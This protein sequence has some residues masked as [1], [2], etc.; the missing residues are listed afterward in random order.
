MM[1][2]TK[3]K[4]LLNFN[5]NRDR[6]FGFADAGFNREILDKNLTRLAEIGNSMAEV[7][8]YLTEEEIRLLIQRLHRLWYTEADE[9]GI[10]LSLLESRSIGYGLEKS[11]EPDFVFFLQRVLEKPSNWTPSC[12]KGFLHSTLRLWADLNPAVRDA[13]SAFIARHSKEVDGELSK[14]AP[15]ISA[16]GPAKLGKDTRKRKESYLMGPSAVLMPTT[17]LNYSYFSDMLLS[18]FQDVRKGEYDELKSALDLHNQTRTDKILIPA[19]IK[20]EGE[21]NKNLLDIATRRIGDPFDESKWAAFDGA[22]TEQKKDL[23]QARKI[24]L[25]WITQEI[26]R[27]FFEVLCHDRER[28][29]FWSKHAHQITNFTV[30]GSNWSR[31]QVLGYLPSQTVLKHFN[32][33]ESTVDNCALA[34]YIGDY[35]VIEFTQVG[36]L[37]A[38]RVDGSNYRQAFRHARSLSKID[39]LKIPTI[40]LLYDL[41]HSRF[42]RE[43]KMDHRGSWAWRMNRWIDHQ[44]SPTIDND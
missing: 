29:D 41:D 25:G 10:E 30:F 32:T 19:L 13:N 24:L 7:R 11:M 34:M 28:K 40:T 4:N 31:Q 38:Y 36:A 42:A 43:G 39:D 9:S 14:A 1:D 44:V 20:K 17:R 16:D 26:I 12:L 27:S 22:T 5:F 18:Y 2:R 23:R 3:V 21:Y 15:Y 33:V 37:Y 6:V 35:V 8:D